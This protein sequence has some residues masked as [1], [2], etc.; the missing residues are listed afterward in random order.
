MWGCS[1]SIGKNTLLHKNNKF[2][3]RTAS[4]NTV[5]VTPS[6]Q[7]DQL[8]LEF[9]C[10]FKWNVIYTIDSWIQNTSVKVLFQVFWNWKPVCYIASFPGSVRQLFRL[11]TTWIVPRAVGFL[12]MENIPRGVSVPWAHLQPLRAQVFIVPW[13]TQRPAQP[14]RRS[15]THKPGCLLGC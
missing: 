11:E 15:G 8:P 12:P 14:W 5:R 7:I 13:P 4:Q 6:E 9:K 1:Y 10:T 3:T 2:I